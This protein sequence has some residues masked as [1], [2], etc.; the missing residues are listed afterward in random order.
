MDTAVSLMHRRL[1]QVRSYPRP[2][3]ADP[4]LTRDPCQVRDFQYEITPNP[5]TP[6]IFPEPDPDPHRRPTWTPARPTRPPQYE[7]RKLECVNALSH[8]YLLLCGPIS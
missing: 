6:P 2:H 8:S 3:G 1:A 7:F 5:D 4:S